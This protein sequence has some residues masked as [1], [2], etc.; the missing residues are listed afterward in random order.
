[1]FAP[2]AL[3]AF[4][5][6]DHTKLVIDALLLNKEANQSEIYIYCD[7]PRGIEDND[8]VFQVRK[9][10][11]GVSGFKSIHIIERDKNYGLA[12]SIIS[13]V[14]EILEKYESVIVL[15]DDI[16]TSPY[17]LAFM[18]DGLVKYK[19]NTKVASI[20][21]FVYPVSQKLPNNFFLR[22]ADCWGWA[23][24]RRAWQKFNSNGIELLTKLKNNELVD[25]F[26]FHGAYHYS[27]M[28]LN[29]IK[30][31]NQSWAIR[32][33][34]SMY[35][36]NM[37]TLYPGKSLVNN[38]GHDDSG[39]HSGMT[40]KYDSVI[41]P[42]RI[43]VED[44]KVEVSKKAYAAFE[45]FLKNKDSYQVN[46]QIKNKIKSFIKLVTPPLLIKL[47]RKLISYKFSKVINV[48][49]NNNPQELI[50]FNG[51]Y[52]NWDDAIQNCVGY[53]SSN[54]LERVI[55][56]TK[57]VVN[58]EAA[59]ER[60]SVVFEQIDYSWPLLSG[61]LLASSRSSGILNVIDYGGSLG[62]SYH[63]NRKF[64]NL[65][66]S[67]KWNV[68]EQSNYVT[69]GKSLF[70]NDTL[71]FY[72]NISDCLLENKP[73][74]ILLSSVLQ[75]LPEPYEILNALAKLNADVIILDRT[76]YSKKSR[77]DFLSIQ[78]VPDS[79]YSAT[80]P[81]WF[82]IESKVVQTLMDNEYSLIESFPA[83]DNLDDRAVWKGH[84]FCKSK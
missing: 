7:G 42:N 13:G 45:N 57:L 73:N 84:I 18:N 4:R 55:S 35:L 76:C 54:I 52:F 44:I 6:P 59:Y 79:I 36:E 38:I 51:E 24:W 60:D 83:L 37:L 21:G 68:I 10:V 74:I 82:L 61:L 9:Y 39:T 77:I 1:M 2:I 27:E 67:V 71:N 15:E 25:D 14:T 65:I 20:H 33:H 72:D 16:V 66:S 62:S 23:T 30:G 40:N 47:Y 58:G 80:Y 32:W 81:C 46:S 48:N 63:Q 31:Q 8:L 41:S 5:R 69:A 75:Y 12:K 22:G 64:L 78:T 34:A 26:D 17:F 19:N 49:V 50:T 53:D 3:F 43:E 70:K 29:Q 28:L 56:S 11:R